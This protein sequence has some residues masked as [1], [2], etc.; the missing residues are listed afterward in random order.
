MAAPGA[1]APDAAAAVRPQAAAPPEGVRPTSLGRPVALLS[2]AAFV[3]VASMR[4]GDPLLPQVAH[5]FGVSAGEA[6]VIATAFALAYGLCQ[7]VWGALG[8][9]FGKYRLVA[10]MTL[11]S[12]L[13]GTRRRVRGLA[14]DTRPRALRGRRDG[15][16]DRAARH[17]VRRR[18]RALSR[19]PGGARPLPH[20]H[21]HGPGR[22]PDHRRRARRAGRLARGLPADRRP[23]PAGGPPAHGRGALAARAARRCS[24]P[25]SARWRWSGATRSCSAAPGRA[26]S[27]PRCSSRASCST[28]R[29][30]SSAPICEP[31]SASTTRS[32][33]CCSAAS[34]SAACSTRSRSASSWPGSA[35]KGW[36]SCGG[37]ILALAFAIVGA[38][39]LALMAPAITALGLG[40]YMLHAT[41]QTNATQMAP[42]ARGLAVST[43]A[44]ALF[45]GQ[46]GGVWLAG[47]AV[48]RI[49]FAPVFAAM[50]IGLMALGAVFARPGRPPPGRGL[51]RHARAPPRTPVGCGPD[52]ARCRSA[53]ARRLARA[54]GAAGQRGRRALGV[55]DPGRVRLLRPPGQAAADLGRDPALPTGSVPVRRRQRLWRPHPGRRHAARARLRQGRDHSGL[56]GVACPGAGALDLGRPRLRPERRRRRFSV[57]GS[58]E[59]AVSRILAAAGG[60][61]APRT[62]RRL[63][64]AELRAR[65]PAPAGH[66]ARHP[67]LPLAPQADRSAGRAGQGRVPAGPGPGQDHAR[68]GAMGLARRAAAA[69]RPSCA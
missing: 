13:T 29:S 58:G 22:R 52:P 63:S 69:R 18:Q 39:P 16:R 12:A 15:G 31:A 33:A 19:P 68:R 48:D 20:R 66:P 59:G 50:G 26:S 56:P 49:G 53:G 62:R 14:R 11:V 4:V 60:R 8:D 28:A 44:N 34:A 21:D 55:L 38:G 23:V 42:E 37:A 43:F 1:S 35:S 67:E 2:A 45:L 6:S 32:S 17:G 25:R 30:P 3:S 46:A 10:L 47:S 64:R 54:G 41:L 36:H 51:M 61:P 9:R 40:L 24:P 27:S 57:Q 7:L 65:G 5:E